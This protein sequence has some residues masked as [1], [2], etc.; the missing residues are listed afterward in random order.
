MRNRWIDVQSDGVTIQ[1][2][3]MRA[4]ANEAQIGGIGNQSRS[5]FVL[6]D[7]V[8]SDAHGAIVSLGGGSNLKLLRNDISRGGQEASVATRRPTL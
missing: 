7:N 2:F 5:N 4:S 6:Q 1:G 3:R 8:L